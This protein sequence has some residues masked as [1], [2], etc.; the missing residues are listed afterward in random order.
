[1]GRSS[2]GATSMDRQRTCTRPKSLSVSV[3]AFSFERTRS[4]TGYG[5]AASAQAVTVK[6]RQLY[7]LN[8][9]KNLLSYRSA[10]RPAMRQ[11]MLLSS[12]RSIARRRTMESKCQST[13]YR[14]QLHS[15]LEA[16][17]MRA[18]TC[19]TYTAAFTPGRYPPSFQGTCASSDHSRP[20]QTNLRASGRNPAPGQS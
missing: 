4:I 6:C 3:T 20:P 12:Q 17:V 2:K 8:E 9:L 5:V 15:M 7:N 19:V 11:G 14:Y 13:G 18:Y 10:W 1:M 16:Q